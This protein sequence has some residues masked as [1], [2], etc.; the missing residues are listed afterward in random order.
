MYVL[1][2]AFVAKSKI[3][4]GTELENAES[5]ERIE[6]LLEVTKFSTLR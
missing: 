5:T 4:F 6:W 3:E 2:Q 1:L